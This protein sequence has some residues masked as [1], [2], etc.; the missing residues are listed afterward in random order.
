MKRILLAFFFWLTFITSA[1]AEEINWSLDPNSIV[2][3]SM[4]GSG[5]Y[6]EGAGNA[7]NIKDND[8]TTNYGVNCFAP[9]YP[10]PTTSSYSYTCTITLP[11]PVY[12][13]R[14]EI[15]HGGIIKMGDASWYVD[16]CRND[17]W[18]NVLNGNIASIT[19]TASNTIGLNNVTKVRVGSNATCHSGSLNSYQ[20]GFAAYFISELRIWGAPPYVDIGLKA[21]D[22]T[23]VIKIAC[24]PTEILTSPLR[25]HKNGITYGI[26]LV[27]PADN[28]ASKF[29]IK[30]NYGVKALAKLD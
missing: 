23:G 14:I 25:I 7:Y 10:Y 1:L 8:V 24:E 12:L 27:D 9:P 15:I 6:S 13:N 17:N 21:Y 26:I 5:Y 2:E 28:R 3:K 4:S 30:T 20:S 29:R 18:Y 22:G 16:I 19:T 11:Q